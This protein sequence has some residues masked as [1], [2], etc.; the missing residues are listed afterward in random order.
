LLMVLSTMDV[1]VERVA[2]I[3]GVLEIGIGILV[4]SDDLNIMVAKRPVEAARQAPHGCRVEI[5][6]SRID[7]A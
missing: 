4:T 5:V 2:E 3:K 7:V 6:N 1:G